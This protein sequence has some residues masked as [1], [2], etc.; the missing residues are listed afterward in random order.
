MHSMMTMMIQKEGRDPTKNKQT[1]LR[2]ASGDSLVSKKMILEGTQ[3]NSIGGRTPWDTWVTGERL[4]EHLNGE[5]FQVGP[6][7]VR[8]TSLLFLT[9]EGGAWEG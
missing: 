4:L 1:K 2:I 8:N 7:G 9:E 6:F 5:V 3:A